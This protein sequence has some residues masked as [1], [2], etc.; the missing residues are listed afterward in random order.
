MCGKRRKERVADG[1]HDDADQIR[2]IMIQIAGK[3]VRHIIEA[4]MAL[5]TRSRMSS[6]TYPLPFTTSETVL[7]DTP[8]FFATSRMPT[9]IAPSPL[10]LFHRCIL[11][12]LLRASREILYLFSHS[13]EPVRQSGNEIQLLSV[14][15]R[16]G[17][18]LQQRL[19]LVECNHQRC[20]RTGGLDGGCA[21]ISF[22]LLSDRPCNVKITPDWQA[23][24]CRN[25]RPHK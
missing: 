4:C 25:R 16:G 23:A 3:L 9:M 13:L 14:D 24:Q 22:T 12:R 18:G 5:R 8:A 17:E 1:G 6:D 20:I 10:S 11:T 2:A 15:S 7:R 21:Q 19:G